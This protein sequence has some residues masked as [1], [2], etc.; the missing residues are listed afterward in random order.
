MFMFSSFVPSGNIIINSQIDTD[1]QVNLVGGGINGNI[2]INVQSGHI[3]IDPLNLTSFAITENIFNPFPNSGQLIVNGVNNVFTRIRATVDSIPIRQRVVLVGTGTI[4]IRVND[5][6]GLNYTPIN[7]AN[8][9]DPD[10]T[11]VQDALDRLA[12]AVSGLLGG[13]IP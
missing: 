10:P 13:P 9:T 5:A 6:S 2:I 4:L 7:G 3:P 12:A 8:W 11:T 1:T